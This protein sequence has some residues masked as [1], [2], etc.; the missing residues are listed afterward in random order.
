VDARD[1]RELV[2]FDEEG[3]RHA[4]L[5][6]T[7]RLWS[8]VVC[9]ERNQ[10]LGPI[11]DRDSDALVLVVTGRVVVQVDRGRKRRD[12]WETALVRAGSELTITNATGDP[13]VVLLV[14]APPP[15]RRAVSE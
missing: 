7:D 1:L 2:Q 4:P 8:E 15:P 10:S 3:P 13:A 6:E 5:F 11:A 14:A 9:L 12:Q